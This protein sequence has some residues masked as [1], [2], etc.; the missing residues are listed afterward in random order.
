MKYFKAQLLYLKLT[1]ILVPIGNYFSL[2]IILT[3][4]GM[5]PLDPGLRV[6]A[7]MSIP[8]HYEQEMGLG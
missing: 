4:P 6:I 3:V 8:H 7:I 5:G 2:F 1:S